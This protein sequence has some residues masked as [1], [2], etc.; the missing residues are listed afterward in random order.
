[1]SLEKGAK[2]EEALRMLNDDLQFQMKSIEQ[3]ND[4]TGG[5]VTPLLMETKLRE[6]FDTTVK[7]YKQFVTMSAV[8]LD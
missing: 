6:Q 5:L 2:E 4:K 3:H 7:G 8:E 1:M